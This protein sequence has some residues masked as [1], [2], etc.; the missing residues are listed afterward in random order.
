MNRASEK[1][2]ARNDPDLGGWAGSGVGGPKNTIL[3]NRF[4]ELIYEP[5][6]SA[7]Y[8]RSLRACDRIAQKPAEGGQRAR[9][10]G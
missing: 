2:D 6:D 5:P 8:L 9:T 10:Y 4:P 7:I 1:P 3:K